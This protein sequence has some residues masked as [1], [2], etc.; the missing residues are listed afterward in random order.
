M[1]SHSH[2][3]G[4]RADRGRLAA[5]GEAASERSGIFNIGIEGVM[6]A[7]AFVAADADRQPFQLAF[8]GLPSIGEVLDVMELRASV[9]VEAAGLAADFAGSFFSSAFFFFAVSRAS[10]IAQVSS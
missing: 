2:R 1:P 5:I 7:G 8:D 4:G 6:L 3:V 9:E 10:P